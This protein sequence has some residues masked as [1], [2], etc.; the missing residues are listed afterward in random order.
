MSLK[1]LFEVVEKKS[2]LLRKNNSNANGQDFWKPIKDEL[3]KFNIQATG[4]KKIKNE[5]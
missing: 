3:S 5:Y 4:W 2:F 1:L